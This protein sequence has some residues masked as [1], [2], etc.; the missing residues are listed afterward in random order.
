MKQIYGKVYIFFSIV[1][2]IY[3]STLAR[4]EEGYYL[5]Y[6]TSI[7][8]KLKYLSKRLDGKKWVVE[9]AW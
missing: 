2:P 9:H 5:K 3:I 7:A 6:K 1:K 4:W 8:Q